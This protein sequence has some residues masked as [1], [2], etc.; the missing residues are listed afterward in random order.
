MFVKRF[1]LVVEVIFVA[2][3]LL[4]GQELSKANFS[5]IPSGLIRLPSPDVLGDDYLTTI[6]V[7]LVVH[8]ATFLIMSFT[9][10]AEVFRQAR[11]TAIEIFGLI[12]AVTLSSLVLFLFFTVV[13]SP[14]LMLNIAVITFLLFIVGHIVIA[15]LFPPPK[16]SRNP[17]S[18]GWH[19]IWEGIRHIIR[20]TGILV[21]I[22]AVCPLILAK[23]FVSDRDIANQITQIR[24]FFAAGEEKA[25]WG[26]INAMPGTT[27]LRPIEIQF[28][29]NDKDTMYVLERD[30]AFYRAPYVVGKNT[31]ED[32]KVKLLDIA[33]KLGEVEVENGALGFDHHPEYGKPG[34]PNAGYIYLYYT[35]ARPKS[36]TNYLSRFDV[37]LPTLAQRMASET[38]ILILGRNDS[39]FHNG[40]SVEFGP[41]GY[42]YLALGEATE[43][44]GH[45]RIDY[46]LFGGI[47]RIDVDRQGGDKSHPVRRQPAE[48]KSSNY[49]IPNDNPFSGQPNSLE[50]FWAL[51]LRNP[52]RISFDP[53]TGDLWAGDVGSDVWEEVNRITKGGNYQFPRFE[54]QP[55]ASYKS[56][57]DKIIGKDRTPV[58]TYRHTSFDRAVIGGIVYRG[59]KYPSLVGKYIFADSYSGKVWMFDSDRDRVEAKEV[60]LLARAVG[61]SAQRGVTSLHE[62]PDGDILLTALGQAG[63]ATGQILRLVPGDEAK[64]V[65]VQPS[66]PAAPITKAAARGLYLADCARCHGRTGNGEGPDSKSMI[67][68]FNL[69]GMPDFTS[70]AYH[71]KRSDAEIERVILKGGPALGLTEGMPPWEGIYS[72]ADITAVTEY[73]RSLRQ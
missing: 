13:Y 29:P 42:L 65:A 12:F 27:F 54:G 60:G 26:L 52:F 8:F 31:P 72:A 57:P 55:P 63:T 16:Q 18:I 61:F 39:G 67:E 56:N 50:E 53:K 49:F 66:A 58:F 17:L 43:D 28:P 46:S 15:S 40:G 2:L 23:M 35:N 33:E 59:K 41:D 14:A 7:F 70:G 34:S 37:S 19:L 24:M 10:G 32:S 21:L 69:K 48:G 62:S 9:A 38:P 4:I 1:Y 20:P 44:R 25:D 36:Q 73:V 5:F 71:D 6:K 64:N 47:S 22:F 68:A 3:G 11:R 51:G 30:G 45:Q